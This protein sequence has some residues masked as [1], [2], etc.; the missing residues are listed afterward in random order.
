MMQTNGDTAVCRQRAT[1]VDRAMEV[2]PMSRAY[3]YFDEYG[4]PAGVMLA[5]VL[6]VAGLFYGLVYLIARP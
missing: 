1:G 4:K 3:H 2:S 5:G 6:L